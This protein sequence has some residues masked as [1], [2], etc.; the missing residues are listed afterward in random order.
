MLLLLFLF[1]E[2]NTNTTLFV[3]L[4][5]AVALR[6]SGDDSDLFPDCLLVICNCRVVNVNLIYTLKT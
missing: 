6:I 5:R 2:T 1:L 4:L 3:P